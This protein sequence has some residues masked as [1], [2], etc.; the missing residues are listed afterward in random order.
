M[1][2]ADKITTSCVIAAAEPR[3]THE[4]F[5]MD[6]HNLLLA[7]A[8]SAT[9]NAEPELKRDRAWRRKSN[10]LHRRHDQK[11]PFK[12]GR[13]TALKNW[14]HLYTSGLKRSRARQLKIEYPRIS[15]QQRRL[16]AQQEFWNIPD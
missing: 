6:T 8:Q 9:N 11:R 15:N 13:W 1:N 3:S 14:K 5:N 16:N 12:A 2:D 10:A 7:Q 4:L